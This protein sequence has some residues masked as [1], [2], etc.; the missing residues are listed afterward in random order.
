M[1]KI[2]FNDKYGLTQSVLRGIKTQTRRIVTHPKKYKGI[3]VAGFYAYRK[4]SDKEIVELC[5]YDEDEIP[6]DDGQILPRYKIGEVVA[7]AQSYMDCGNM[8]VYEVDEDGYPIKPI[9]SG[10]FNKMFVKP[11]LMPHQIVITNIR[12][13]RLQDISDDDCLKEGIEFDHKAQSF[14][15]GLNNLTKSR[16]WLGHTPREAYAVLIDKT[17]GKCT[18]ENNPYVWVYEFKLVK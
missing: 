14:Y 1:K 4:P 9:K 2:M 15:C 8:P 5:M 7:I 3:D 12:I 6:I 18:W 16:Q 11:E 13:Q 17:S 10:Y